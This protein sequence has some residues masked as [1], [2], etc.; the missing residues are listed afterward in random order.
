METIL[1]TLGG[2]TIGLI[3]G[4]CFGT[5]FLDKFGKRW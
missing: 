3:L 5:G 4:V 2:F 1:F